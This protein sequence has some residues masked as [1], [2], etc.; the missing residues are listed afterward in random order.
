MSSLVSRVHQAGVELS[1]LLGYPHQRL[2]ESRDHGSVQPEFTGRATRVLT[3]PGQ[4]KNR[5]R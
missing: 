2:G 4:L 5:Q 1:T 3:R